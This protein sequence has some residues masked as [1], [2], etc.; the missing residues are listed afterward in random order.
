MGK[1]E[2][3]WIQVS[4]EMVTL[5]GAGAIPQRPWPVEP[6]ALGFRF[7]GVG[8]PATVHWHAAPA[9]TALPDEPLVLLIAS[10]AVER[11]FGPL[12]ADT[13]RSF[14]ISAELREIMMAV[15]DCTLP[16]PVREPYRLA[17]SIELLCDTLRLIGEGA[18]V[19]VL[20]QCQLSR[21]DSRRVLAARA[22]IDERWREKLTLAGLSRACGLNRSKLTR[23][24]REMFD[25]SIA[26]TLAEKRL[27]GARAM[28][29]S[30]DL[31]IASIG[32]RCGYLN[33]ASFSRAFTRRFGTAPTQYRARK[34]AA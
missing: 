31:P 11:L 14:H 21:D 13:T 17:K 1:V 16:E 27:E 24:F 26:D 10:A 19:P 5:I 15:H 18:L 2:R 12:P 3:D 28:L 4:H 9:A 6:V 32:Y 8:T 29:L 33:N 23:G 7:G 30:T 22:M 34:L 20:G 25:C